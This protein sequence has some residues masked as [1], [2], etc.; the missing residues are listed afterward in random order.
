MLDVMPAMVRV[1]VVVVKPG[2]L[3]AVAPNVIAPT[4][5][6][7]GPPPIAGAPP[8]SAAET[9]MSKAKAT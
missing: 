8:A 9:A 3:S 1:P 5:M 7:P 2:L 4:D 6:V